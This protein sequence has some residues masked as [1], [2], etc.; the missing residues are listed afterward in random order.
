MI[1]VSPSQNRDYLSKFFTIQG[2]MKRRLV[3][4]F[5]KINQFIQVE[6]SKMEGVPALREIIRPDD[7]VCKI[8]LKDAYAVV[9]MPP[10]SMDYPT[11]ENQGIVYRYRSLAFGLSV[12]PRI[13]SKIMC[14][15]IEPLKKE[16][17]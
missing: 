8:D 9:P 15:A 4:N 1:E 12:S 3:L 11:F 16:G 6:H 2:K 10:N 13:F 5:Q 14:Y 7:F 17:M